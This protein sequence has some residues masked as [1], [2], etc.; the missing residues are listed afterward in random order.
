MGAARP[1]AESRDRCR[2][3]AA[4]ARPAAATAAP[5]PGDL[6]EGPGRDDPG[7]G[8]RDDRG[9]PTVTALDGT[10]TWHEMDSLPRLESCSTRPVRK[11]GTEEAPDSELRLFGRMRHGII[12]PSR[13]RGNCER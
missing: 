8:A 4:P 6:Q 10:E 13:V 3:R 11:A 9:S 2:R 5:V 12:D 1:A 7:R